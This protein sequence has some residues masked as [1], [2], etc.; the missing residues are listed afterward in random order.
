VAPVPAAPV[1][2]TVRKRR[3]VVL[4]V[5]GATSEIFTQK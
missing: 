5:A 1:Q 2:V 4:P 3:T